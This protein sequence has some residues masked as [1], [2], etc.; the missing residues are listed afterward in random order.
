MHLA[1]TIVV[2]HVNIDAGRYKS[3]KIICMG[4]GKRGAVRGL[5]GTHPA[6]SCTLTKL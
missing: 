2:I 6:D 1:T 3:P 5:E 4:N